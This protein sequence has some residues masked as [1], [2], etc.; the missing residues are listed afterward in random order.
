[1][2]KNY[3][4][5]LTIVYF[6]AHGLLCM[7][8]GTWWDDW[9]IKSMSS[10]EL[11]AFALEIGRPSLIYIYSFTDWIPEYGYRVLTFISF[12]I[13]T[14]I[15]Y[16]IL[17]LELKLPEQDCFWISAFFSII[18]LNDERIMLAVFPYTL[19]ILL[20][21]IGFG[22]FEYMINYNRMNLKHRIA[23]LLFFF[24]SFI[25]N[26]NLIFYIIIPTIIF[27]RNKYKIEVI[28]R[29]FDYVFLPIIFF[30]LKNIWFIPYESYAG[31][32]SV[33]ISKLLRASLGFFI[34]DIDIII[35]T[36]SNLLHSP[37]YVV[38]MIVIILIAYMLW[39]YLRTHK[40][41]IIEIR[42][43]LY[44]KYDS[45]RLLFI[46]LYVLTLGVFPYLVARGKVYINASGV[47]GRDGIL[48]VFGI[49][50]ILFWLTSRVNINN[51]RQILNVVIVMLGIVFF[52]NQYVQ[53]QIDYYDQIGFQRYILINK[54]QI[55]NMTNLIYF[56]NKEDEL[57]IR[58]FY[59]LNGNARLAL[60]TQSKLFLDG[61]DDVSMLKNEK[62]LISLT[63]KVYNMS[64]YDVR[65]K[66][67]NGII[68]F[69]SYIKN[70]D[71]FRLK[72]L[73][74]RDKN[75][76]YKEIEEKCS[77]YIVNMSYNKYE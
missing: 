45:Y 36:I 76:F 70:E 13:C 26:S 28:K 34:A 65:N 33:T 32:N 4:I 71:F 40:L 41:N 17:K 77:M 29:Y 11:K 46:G 53:Y 7:I 14:I 72:F 10:C 19:G 66:E 15:L 57:D 6:L 16:F 50:M 39:E 67:V 44:D 60:G 58:R 35:V 55:E 37:L 68:D 31:Y 42:K 9:V 38:R 23:N 2:K 3:F 64:E 69:K 21:M 54:S 74:I 48:A 18:P 61:Y 51:I 63:Q 56:S 5:L 47:M 12:Y 8:S 62:D 52:N 24:A 59:T 30:L 25:L 49:S 20:F 1:M 75:E 22:H 27:I 43:V 73:E